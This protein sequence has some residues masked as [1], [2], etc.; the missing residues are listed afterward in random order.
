MLENISGMKQV[1]WGRMRVR[2]AFTPIIWFTGATGAVLVSLAAAGAPSWVI[3]L[4]A[5]LWAICVAAGLFAFF[6]FMFKNPDRLQS[7]DYQIQ[8]DY[9]HLTQGRGQPPAMESSPLMSNAAVEQ[10]EDAQ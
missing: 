2:N 1:Q 6:W 7:E 4:S 9:L 3:A 10:I 8:K 5:V